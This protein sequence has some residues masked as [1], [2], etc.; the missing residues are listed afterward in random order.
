MTVLRVE[1]SGDTD[2]D[3]PMDD[4]CDYFESF[5][6]ILRSD[7][8]G[9]LNGQNLVELDLVRDPSAK[10]LQLGKHV[11]TRSDDGRKITVRRGAKLDNRMKME[12]KS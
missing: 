3:L 11:V 4:V 1:W 6:Q 9:G 12:R 7:M 2:E 8:P 10:A 5:G